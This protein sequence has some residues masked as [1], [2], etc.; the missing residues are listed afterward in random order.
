MFEDA[1]YD[2]GPRATQFPQMIGSSPPHVWGSKMQQSIANEL[3]DDIIMEIAAWCMTLCRIE[4]QDAHLPRPYRWITVTHIC[5][6]WRVVALSVPALWSHVVPTRLE[7]VSEF[8]RRSKQAPLSVR[9]SR[10]Y[11]MNLGWLESAK[12]ILKEMHRIEHMELTVSMSILLKMFSLQTQQVPRLRS[13]VLRNAA[14][15][16]YPQWE[17]HPIHRPL[18]FF[19]Q[20]QPPAIRHLHLAHYPLVAVRSML[21]WTTLTELVLQTITGF[22]SIVDLLDTLENLSHLDRLTLDHV[23]EHLRL[24][25]P[26]GANRHFATFLPHLQHLCIIDRLQ[27]ITAFLSQVTLQHTTRIRLDDGGTTAT[28]SDIAALH[29]ALSISPHGVRSKAFGAQQ[30]TSIVIAPTSSK[31]RGSWPQVAFTAYGTQLSPAQPLLDPD[32][33]LVSV[34]MTPRSLQWPGHPVSYAL[35]VLCAAFQVT[36]VRAVHIRG[37][38]NCEWPTFWSA[39]PHLQNVRLDR[40]VAHC[41]RADIL[42][43]HPNAEVYIQS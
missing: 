25:P 4:N 9:S 7:S 15:A 26:D 36:A 38:V 13:V 31:L 1:A 43:F 5:H 8:L 11:A 35:N 2:A 37:P 40:R 28:P 12:I 22:S 17:T 20:L 23:D 27:F 16:R 19:S 14:F 24:V 42:A 39:M 10:R 34:S 6:R 29:A 33:S 32:Q 21:Q 3:P 30:L 41:Y 18:P